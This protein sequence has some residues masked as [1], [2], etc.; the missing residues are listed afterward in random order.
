[1]RPPGVAAPRPGL[2]IAAPDGASATTLRGLL[3][4]LYAPAHFTARVLEVEIGG[5]TVRIYGTV[6]EEQAIA[7]IEEHL[8]G[9]RAERRA[10]GPSRLVPPRAW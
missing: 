10:S 3:G 2:R 4:V 6:T 5:D 8:R 1:M 7:A 9:K